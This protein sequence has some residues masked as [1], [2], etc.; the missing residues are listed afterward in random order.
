M[1]LFVWDYGVL[2]SLGDFHGELNLTIAL[3]F[4]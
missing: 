4:Y 2:V 1:Q 3:P